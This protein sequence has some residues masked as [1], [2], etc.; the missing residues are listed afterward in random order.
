[1]VKFMVRVPE[2]WKALPR[3]VVGAENLNAFKKVLELHQPKGSP[4]AR[5]LRP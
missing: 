1:M 4:E 5:A 3:Q 2:I